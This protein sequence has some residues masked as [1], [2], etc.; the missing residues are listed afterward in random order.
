MAVKTKVGKE[1]L[2]LVDMFKN[3]PQSKYTNRHCVKL[4]TNLRSHINASNKKNL[5]PKE[6][7][8]SEQQCKYENPNMA[9]PKLKT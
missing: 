8:V 2:S 5:K 6:H 4:I 3:T 9:I 1:F 7:D